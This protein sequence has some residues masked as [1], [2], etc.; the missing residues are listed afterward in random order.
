MKRDMAFSLSLSF[1]FFLSLS[2]VFDLILRS[3]WFS[4]GIGRKNGFDLESMPSDRT[5][6]VT[7]QLN[8]VSSAK[9][10]RELLYC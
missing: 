10:S 8:E 5:T 3:R 2:L 6:V 7:F 9:G 1:F 4:E